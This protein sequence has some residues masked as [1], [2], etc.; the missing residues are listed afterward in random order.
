MMEGRKEMFYLTTHSTHFIYGYMEG[1]KE[2]NVLFNN[3]LNTFY[4]WLYG[5]KE[6][7]YLKTHS[8]HFIYGYMATDIW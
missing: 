4:L 7:F 6:M 3:A 5:M 2:G 8:T 1:R